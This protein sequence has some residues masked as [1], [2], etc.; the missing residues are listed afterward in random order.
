MLLLASTSPRR[1]ELLEQAGIIVDRI[2][3]PN[4]DET[5]KKIELPMV[6]VRRMALEKCNAVEKKH[7]DFV[8]AADTI[9]FRGR[10]ILGKPENR[11]V[12]KKYL[13]LLSGCRHRVVTSV[14]LAHN[15]KIRIRNVTTVVKMKR[16]STQ[17]INDYLETNEWSGKAG[18]Y[19]IQGKAA[20]FIPAISG[21]YTNVVG[22][23]L[24]ETINLLMGSGFRERK[25]EF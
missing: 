8:L 17:E 10:R 6:Y 19:A 1:K 4:I 7:S 3:D 2:V 12:A 25:K 24:T 18:G 9:V 15:H 22:L 14:C 11:Y 21:S 16:L 5:P 23:P 13:N 20:F